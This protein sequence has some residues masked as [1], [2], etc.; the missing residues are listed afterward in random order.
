MATSESLV[1]QGQSFFVLL[2][3]VLAHAGLTVL[4]L[5]LVA[6]NG[7]AHAIMRARQAELRR[8]RATF[9]HDARPFDARRDTN[10]G[11]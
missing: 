10:Q 11:W 1:D 8:A 9:T 2:G 7:R 4:C 3:K 5:P 6:V